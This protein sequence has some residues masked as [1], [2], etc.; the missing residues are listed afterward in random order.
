MTTKSL[1]HCR[2]RILVSSLNFILQWGRCLYHQLVVWPARQGPIHALM[3]GSASRCTAYPP[4]TLFAGVQRESVR[5]PLVPPLPVLEGDII[6]VKHLNPASWLA[7]WILAT[8]QPAHC[9]TICPHDDFCPYR[10][11]LKCFR[12]GPLPAT[13]SGPCWCWCV[14]Q[15]KRHH[16]EL[17][18]PPLSQERVFFPV[19]LIRFDLPIPTS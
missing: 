15:S 9:A 3:F 8:M 7:Y 11:H 6:C 18:R 4:R 1:S 13:P 14:D 2:H 5:V 19:R 10:Q 16:F 12:A 17:V